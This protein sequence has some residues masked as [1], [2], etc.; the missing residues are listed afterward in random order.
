MLDIQI[1]AASPPFDRPALGVRAARLLS[2]AEAMG[3]LPPGEPIYR[4]DAQAMK[5]PVE[6]LVRRGIGRSASL[7]LAASDAPGRIPPPLLAPFHEPEGSPVPAA[8]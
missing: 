6:A 5:A 3:I 2:L 4:L 7:P 8:D 1:H